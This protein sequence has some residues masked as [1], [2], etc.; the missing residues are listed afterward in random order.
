MDR[1]VY[2]GA[3]T[4]SLSKYWNGDI[5]AFAP[6]GEH[7][8]YLEYEEFSLFTITV[9]SIPTIA[10]VTRAIET[11]LRVGAI[12]ICMAIMWTTLTFVDIC[13]KMNVFQGHVIFKTL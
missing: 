12:T 1:T 11:T 13:M 10:R 5:L 4:E 8:G 3:Y 6:F 7:D 9:R 2:K